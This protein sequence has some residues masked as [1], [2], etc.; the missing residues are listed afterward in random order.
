MAAHRQ[1][2]YNIVYAFSSSSNI[3]ANV[4]VVIVFAS[5]MAHLIS[6]SALQD[7]ERVL[8]LIHL[9]ELSDS[10]NGG[11]FTHLDNL[12]LSISN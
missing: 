10:V 2:K 5:R 8:H 3:C 1:V 11:F 12:S 9:N 7:S 4:N 6:I